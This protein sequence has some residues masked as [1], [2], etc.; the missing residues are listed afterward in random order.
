MLANLPTH[1]S[2]GKSQLTGS[3]IVYYNDPTTLVDRM[4]V[5][6]GSIAAGNKSPVLKNDLSQIFDEL[7]K[8]GVFDKTIHERMYK[9]YLAI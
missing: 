1:K 6:M 7:L 2:S 5:I 8:I 9:K 4:Q 3:G